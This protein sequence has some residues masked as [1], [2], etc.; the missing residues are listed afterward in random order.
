MRT[1]YGKTFIYSSFVFVQHHLPLWLSIKYSLSKSTA[2]KNC[3]LKTTENSLVP[4]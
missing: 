4:L 2:S 3:M 1:F